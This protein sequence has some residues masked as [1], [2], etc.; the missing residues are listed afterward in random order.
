MNLVILDYGVGNIKSIQFAFDRLGVTAV[1]SND[2][3]LI[4]AADKIIFPGVG[5]ASSA[6]NKLKDTGL[7]DDIKKLKQ[8]VLGICLGMQLMCNKTEEGQ[9]EGLGIFDVTVKRFSNSVKV[10][11]MGWNTITNLKSSLFDGIPDKDYMYLVH[12]YYAENNECAIATTD[13]ELPYASALQKN[14]FYGVQFHPEKS[15]RSGERIL[16]NFLKL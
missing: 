10:P 7:I 14:N 8:P 5:E 1:L 9:T 3:E 6:M 13:Y 15:G 12:S 16:Q 4:K 2:I 11:Q